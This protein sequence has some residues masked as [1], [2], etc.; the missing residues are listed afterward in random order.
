MS[1]SLEIALI[2]IL[3]GLLAAVSAVAGA[4]WWRVRS[5]PLV[6][7]ARLAKE[8]ADRQEALER[9]IAQLEPPASR[10]RLRGFPSL[11]P[12]PRAAVPDRARPASSAAGPTLIA[13]PDVG[14]LADAPPDPAA[15]LNRRFS[16][17]WRMAEDGASADVI[18]R[19]TGQPVGQVE[20]IL[21][22]RRQL[23]VTERRP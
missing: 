10:A 1:P 23:L 15:D 13:V 22:L 2:V 9:L 16:P 8:L 20:L 18:A 5:V 3:V 21:G 19:R 11:V 6:R 7:S 12:S 17:V 14:G 4:L